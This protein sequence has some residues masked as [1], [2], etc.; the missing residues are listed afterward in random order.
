MPTTRNKEDYIRVIRFMDA[1][2]KNKSNRYKDYKDYSRFQFSLRPYHKDKIPDVNNP[3]IKW[4]KVYN[5]GSKTMKSL[6]KRGIVDPSMFPNYKVGRD[7]RVY[8]DTSFARNKGESIRRDLIGGSIRDDEYVSFNIMF[9]GREDIVRNSAKFKDDPFWARRIQLSRGQNLIP[10]LHRNFHVVVQ[11]RIISDY[12]RKYK[13]PVDCRNSSAYDDFWDLMK[14]NQLAFDVDRKAL[15]SLQEGLFIFF[16]N[17]S[18]YNSQGVPPLRFIN[19]VARSD[20][21]KNVNGF[22][23]HKTYQGICKFYDDTDTQSVYPRGG[24]LYVILYFHFKD[25]IEKRAKSSPTETKYKNWC[26]SKIYKI[27]H[28]K[29]V[30]VPEPDDDSAW[31]LSFHYLKNFL[32]YYRICGGIFDGFY[33]DC[34]EYFDIRHENKSVNSHLPSFYYVYANQH[35]WVIQEKNISFEYLEKLHKYHEDWLCNLDSDNVIIIDCD[36]DFESDQSY[37]TDIMNYLKSKFKI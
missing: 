11:K 19:G 10:L 17:F 32:R 29:N 31:G 14:V 24:C 2:N 20:Y 25:A 33:G 28:G 36:R 3:K 27:I 37:Q 1:P 26:I 34:K 8:F 6:I 16:D 18:K 30:I 7:G 5:V 12:L 35:A 13:I 9:Y 4:S 21:W 22:L 15:N 23:K